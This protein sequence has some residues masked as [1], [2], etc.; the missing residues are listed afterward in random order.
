MCK[1]AVF[2]PSQETETHPKR[3][4]PIVLLEGTGILGHKHVL[5]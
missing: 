2:T 5:E 3:I 1:D 4:T